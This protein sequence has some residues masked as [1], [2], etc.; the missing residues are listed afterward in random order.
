ME[1]KAGFSWSRQDADA[2]PEAVLG[3]R[4]AAPTTGATT[5]N[6]RATRPR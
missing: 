4:Y 3:Q 5:K 6:K 1:R 2:D